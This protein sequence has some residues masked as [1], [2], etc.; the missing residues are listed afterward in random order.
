M[1]EIR[2]GFC[3]APRVNIE[4]VQVHTPRSGEL[5]EPLLDE[6]TGL[7]PPGAARVSAAPPPLQ[8][9]ASIRRA[10][11]GAAPL[12]ST[13]HEEQAEA[14]AKAL[15]A[16]RQ[17]TP[18]S[19]A[20]VFGLVNA[21]AAVPSLIAYAAI[22]FKVGAVGK[23]GLCVRGRDAGGS[24]VGPD[25]WQLRTRRARRVP[26]TPSPPP[27]PHPTINRTPSTRPTSTFCA[28]SS[29]FPAAFTSWSLSA[30]LPCPLPWARSRTWV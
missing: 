27:P 28:S 29:L 23:V 15:A 4:S 26:A 24:S 25:T 16:L 17:P 1:F 3:W 18:F 7:P 8:R 13:I 10:S 2:L 21:V 30:F 5:E 11:S 14:G 20:A 9:S 19:K 22:V 12:L 6:E